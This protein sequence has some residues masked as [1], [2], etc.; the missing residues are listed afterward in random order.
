MNLNIP[1]W[2]ILPCKLQYNTRNQR[3][4]GRLW[5]CFYLKV[6]SQKGDLPAGQ[7]GMFF[8]S[9]KDESRSLGT[10]RC[11]STALVIPN[12]NFIL[13]AIFADLYRLKIIKSE[14][15]YH[16]KPCASERTRPP[17]RFASPFNCSAKKCIS[18]SHFARKG[19]PCGSTWPYSFII[20]TLTFSILILLTTF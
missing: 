9:P 1:S 11:C 19:K 20:I 17:C 4:K 14:V 13:K 5:A 6:K 10:G 7:L 12:S 8:F 2:T 18:D 15:N 16:P 3:R